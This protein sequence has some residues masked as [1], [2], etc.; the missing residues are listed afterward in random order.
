[1]KKIV[2][3]T[4]ELS[5]KVF[6]SLDKYQLKIWVENTVCAIQHIGNRKSFTKVLSPSDQTI[7]FAFSCSYTFHTS[8]RNSMIGGGGG[9]G[10]RCQNAQ[11]QL[12]IKTY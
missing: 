5:A 7:P 1:M 2:D 3:S 10:E 11:K 6:L 12:I 4:L 9:G 8:Y